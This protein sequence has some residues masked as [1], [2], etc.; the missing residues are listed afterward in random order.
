MPVEKGL[1]KAFLNGNGKLEGPFWDIQF[2]NWLDL[3]MSMEPRSFKK[4]Q[5]AVMRN[6]NHEPTF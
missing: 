4:K 1:N 6:L 2:Q 3:I 5:E